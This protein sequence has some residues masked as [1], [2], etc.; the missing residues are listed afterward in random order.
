M[1]ACVGVCV[2]LREKEGEGSSE[3]DIFIYIYNIYVYIQR[4]RKRD[5]EREREREREIERERLRQHVSVLFSSLLQKR[6]D[7]TCHVLIHAVFNCV[8]FKVTKL[9]PPAVVD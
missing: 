9:K 5:R 2:G 1:R 8:T 4:E 7:E 3:E 6:Y